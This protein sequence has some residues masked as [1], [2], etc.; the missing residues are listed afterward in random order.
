MAICFYY[1]GSEVRAP[2][3]DSYYTLFL[4]ACSSA[5]PPAQ[6]A[7]RPLPQKSVVPVVK[8]DHARF[9]LCSVIAW[10]PGTDLSR[11]RV[12]LTICKKKLDAEKLAAWH[13][14]NLG[15]SGD[16][17]QGGFERVE[18]ATE[19]KPKIVLLE[20]GGNDGLRGLPLAAVTR[21][22]LEAMITAFQEAGAKVVLAGMTLPPNYGPDYI[23]QFDSIFKDLAGS[24]SWR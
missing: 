21:K 13:V 4:A 7:E 5:P 18:S 20:L 17:T 11:G 2:R 22:N 14:V 12:F 23:K 10:P 24:I 9:W 1:P 16:T 3:S 19:L 15:I 8:D 6:V